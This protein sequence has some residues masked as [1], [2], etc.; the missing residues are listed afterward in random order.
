LGRLDEA[1]AWFQKRQAL[2]PGDAARHAEVLQDLRQWAH[3]VG[4]DKK[5]LSPQERQERQRYLDLC[6]RLE[7]K[8]SGAAADAA[9]TKP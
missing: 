6:A 2:W 8:G 1:E 9:N 7:R 5:H 3:Q 4:D